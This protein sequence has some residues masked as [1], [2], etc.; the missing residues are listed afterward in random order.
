MNWWLR[1][2][3]AIVVEETCKRGFSGRSGGNVW[4]CALTLF[5]CGEISSLIRAH[6]LRVFSLLQIQ[7]HLKV[8]FKTFSPETQILSSPKACMM[9]EKIKQDAKTEEGKR[10]TEGEP[11]VLP[12]WLMSCWRIIPTWAGRE[13]EGDR[14]GESEENEICWSGDDNLGREGGGVRKLI[15]T[16]TWRRGA[17]VVGS[18]S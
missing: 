10:K 18:S 12:S 6:L 14:N 3:N 4:A 13:W 17:R 8:R 1:W 11:W 5:L 7:T 2:A 16:A 15:P 9:E